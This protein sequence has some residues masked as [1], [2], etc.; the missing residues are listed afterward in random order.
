LREF[1]RVL[2]SGGRLLVALVNVRVPTTSRLA[3]AG[4]KAIGQPARWPTRAEMANR[5]RSAGFQVDHQKR[6][7]R[8]G[9]VLIPTVLTVGVK[10]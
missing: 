10:Q 3:H 2:C 6:I 5:V 4:S 1:N 7:F 9:G 8:L